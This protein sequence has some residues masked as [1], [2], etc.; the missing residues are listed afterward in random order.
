[1]DKTKEQLRQEA[2]AKLAKMPEKARTRLLKLE[3][4]RR[5]INPKKPLGLDDKKR[6]AAALATL[7]PEHRAR[8]FE[9]E[10]LRRGID[11]KSQ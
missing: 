1:M 11:E 4:L 7:E 9:L 3:A 5:G 6:L 10:A 8:L 2:L